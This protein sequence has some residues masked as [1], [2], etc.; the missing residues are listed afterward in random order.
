M[1]EIL[2][3]S[4]LLKTSDLNLAATLC[5]CNFQVE[6]IDRSDPSK[7]VFLIRRNDLL[8]EILQLYFTHQLKVEP[9]SLFGFLR[10]LKTRI[11]H[12]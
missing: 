7:A 6:A 10:E 3:E 4:D 2:R 11:Y 12:A 5:A 1:N 8:D 9:T